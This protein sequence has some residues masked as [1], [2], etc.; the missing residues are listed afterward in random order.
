MVNDRIEN[1]FL[2]IN[3]SEELVRNKVKEMMET[4]EMCHCQKCYYD[5]CAIVLNSLKPRYVTTEKG[6]LLS[7]LSATNM[8][9]QIDLAVSVMQALILVKDS[10]RH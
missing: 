5:V 10:P 3:I 7:M 9:S 4:Y 6:S 1:D 8:E 2:L